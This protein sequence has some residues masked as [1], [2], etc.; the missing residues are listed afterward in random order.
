MEAK[1]KSG[2]DYWELK[3]GDMNAPSEFLIIYDT[4]D[5]S[6]SYTHRLANNYNLHEKE[7][8]NKVKKYIKED[9]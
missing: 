1:Y 5:G 3:G 8:L 2:R 6:A 7:V 4:G 9:L